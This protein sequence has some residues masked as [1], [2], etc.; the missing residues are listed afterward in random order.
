MA[1]VELTTDNFA[2]TI[3]G[4]D[5]LFIDFWA[6]W[7]GP[8][9]MFSPVFDAASEKFTEATFA[10]LDTEAQQEIAA[11]LEIQSIPTLMAFR[12]GVLVYREAGAMNA[13]SF[14]QLVEAVQALDID[15]VRA[16]ADE[17][18]AR[19]DAEHGDDASLDADPAPA[20]AES[21]N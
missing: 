13:S 18:Q 2:Q 19:H 20:A 7:C 15:E 21:Q 12:G 3:E 10:K 8:C 4:N 6:E 17:A 16:S 9:R 11:A 14:E 1:T 5:T